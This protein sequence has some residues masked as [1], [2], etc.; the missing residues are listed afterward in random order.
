MG[1]ALLASQC[2]DGIN[3][4][5]CENSYTATDDPDSTVQ[6]MLL[7]CEDYRKVQRN[8]R[9]PSLRF[10]Q[11]YQSMTDKFNYLA[12]THPDP[13]NMLCGTMAALDD[14]DFFLSHCSEH[15]TDIRNKIVQHASRL[16]IK[17][18]L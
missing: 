1:A 15:G 18:L 14:D 10:V 9:I 6:K 8:V 2:L 11:V 16:L 12:R 7:K 4:E 3:C 5:E 17:K 13:A